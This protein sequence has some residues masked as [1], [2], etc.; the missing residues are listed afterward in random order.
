METEAIKRFRP[1]CEDPKHLLKPECNNNF[2]CFSSEI[3]NQTSC[4]YHQSG[5]APWLTEITIEMPKK[6][7]Q[8]KLIRRKRCEKINLSSVA[9]SKKAK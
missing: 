5:S 2:P 9:G 8:N 1:A 4:D 6:I 3:F 7:K